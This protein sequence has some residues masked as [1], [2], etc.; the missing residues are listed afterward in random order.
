MKKQNV[1]PVKEQIRNLQKI[2]ETYKV[3]FDVL[4]LTA[5]ID[6]TLNYEENKNIILPLIETLASTGENS[7]IE[8]IGTDYGKKEKGNLRTEKE[9]IAKVELDGLKAEAE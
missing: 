8:K 9:A 2:M 6:S 4:D 3:P 7:S 5:L 1:M